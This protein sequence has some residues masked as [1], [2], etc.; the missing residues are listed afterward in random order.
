MT[1][2]VE[3]LTA[4][5]EALPVEDLAEIIRHA[6]HTLKGQ[7]EPEVEAAWDAEL[8][9]RWEE[10]TS[11]RAQWHPAEDVFAHMREKYS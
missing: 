5:L 6:L 1:Q 9:R 4:E 8:A 11:G 10:I 2:T 3:R 7:F